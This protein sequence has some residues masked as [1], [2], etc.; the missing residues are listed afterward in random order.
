MI[1]SLP[2]RLGVDPHQAVRAEELDLLDRAVEDVGVAGRDRPRQHV[3][4]AQVDLDLALG[5]GVALAGEAAGADAQV[6][7]RDAARPAAR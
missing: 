3:L 6:A 2:D 4:G 1:G 5:V 7:A